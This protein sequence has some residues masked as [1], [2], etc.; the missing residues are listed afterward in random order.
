MSKSILITGGA[1]FI[2]QHLTRKL[3]SEGHSIRILDSFHPQIHGVDGDISVDIKSQVD[4]VRADIR[5]RDALI[6]AVS[7]IDTIVHLA[8][9]TGTGQSMYEIERY[10]SVNVQG[11]AIL[12][13]VLGN[14]PNAKGV[15][16]IV[17][18]S[19]RAIY[20][21]GTYQCATHGKVYPEA[22]SNI[23]MAAGKLEPIC[24]KCA[25]SV[26]MLSTEEDA[27]FKP[28]SMY[29]LTKQVQEQ[30]VLLFARVKGINAF[31]LR[32]QNVY[33]AGQSLKNP[34]TGILAVFSN[35]ARQGQRID[36]YEDG[37]E[38]R[39][40]VYV[41]DV[42]EA[43]TRAIQYNEK[44]IGALNVGGGEAVSVAEV[45]AQ[46]NQY[47]GGHSEIQLSGAFRVGDIRHNLA[48]LDNVNKIL[49]FKPQLSFSKGLKLFLDWA[50]AQPVED[51]NA[52]TK[53]VMELSERSL[54][55]QVK[56]S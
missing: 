48:A 35:L 37:L 51:K 8:A 47:F 27:P 21:E 2:G 52:Y 54:M 13:D 45:A 25:L 10:F 23:D 6:N 53:S 7:G 42:V 12:L 16:N 50:E 34:Y 22:R 19:S 18:A 49:G 55:G 5:D 29:G 28:M 39:D 38:S 30:A 17:V 40:F 41:S 43:T 44:F 20:G 4:L 15:T 26:D 33:G 24:P 31:A 36:V 46:V 56:K 3:L 1:G 9:E 14:E 11:T 32:Y